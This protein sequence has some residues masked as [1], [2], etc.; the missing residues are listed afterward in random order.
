VG[1][2]IVME[3]SVEPVSLSEIKAYLRLDAADTTFDSDLTALIKAARY[4]A[5]DF[6]N[7]AFMAR[8]YDLALDAFPSMPLRVPMPSLVSVESI[9]YTDDDG[10]ITTIPVTDYIIDQISEPGRIAFAKGK[11]W[12]SVSL[13]S[14]NGVVIRFVA[15]SGS[16]PE[17]VKLAIKFFVGFRFENPEEKE[18]PDAFYNL[19]WGDRLVP[20]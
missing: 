13:Q 10:V 20:V 7:R 12:P 14:V 19:L 6:Q 8:T 2:K 16:A 1:L 5:E 18:L 4:A 15:G 17:N 11:S 3:P 9:K